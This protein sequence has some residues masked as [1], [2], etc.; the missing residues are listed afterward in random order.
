[1]YRALR[2]AAVGDVIRIT[3]DI[4]DKAQLD[5]NTNR[6]RKSASDVGFASALNLSGFQSGSTSGSASGNLGLTGD[7]STDARARSTA[8]KSCV[9]RLP[10]WSPGHAQR[11]S[12]HQ[13]LAGNPRELRGPR[14]DAGRHRE[15]ARRH[16][17]NTVAYDK[18]A[19][20]RIS[21]AGRGRLNDVQ[22]PAWG[23]RL[24]DAVNPM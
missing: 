2:A 15:S 21:Y 16:S 7:T 1:M 23:Q 5:N 17:N 13:R 14:P 12:R 22:Q 4:D 8:P 6:S 20:A 10:P 11:Q 18:V 3:I 19:E 9:C 24:F